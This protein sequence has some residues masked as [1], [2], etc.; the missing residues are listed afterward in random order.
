MGGKPLNEP[1]VGSAATT[2]GS[3]YWEV[4][5]D[6]GIFAFGNANY[7]GS[8]PGVFALENDGSD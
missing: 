5:S 2:S 7:Y 3:G 6:G 8:M 1:I 4:A